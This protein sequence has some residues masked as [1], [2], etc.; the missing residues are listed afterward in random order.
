MCGSLVARIRNSAPRGDQRIQAQKTRPHEAS[1]KTFLFADSGTTT[2]QDAQKASLLS[3]PTLACRD[4]SF[5]NKAP[6]N[7]YFK[8]VAGMIPSA[9]AFPIPY[10]TFKGSLVDPRL[11]ASNE[12]ILI[13]RVPR[14]GGRPG[15]PPL[16]LAVPP[17]NPY[18][19]VIAIQPG[20][21]SPARSFIN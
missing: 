17:P 7:P 13:V 5:P 15:Y 1:R 16:P 21:N 2:S 12:H 9:R 8:G 14:A 4:A 11:R 6:T 10:L 18:T 3:R 20:L 19:D